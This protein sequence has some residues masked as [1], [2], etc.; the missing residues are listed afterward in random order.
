MPY[1]AVMAKECLDKPAIQTM[2][3]AKGTH[4]SAINC[5]PNGFPCSCTNS[6]TSGSANQQSPTP[7][8]CLLVCCDTSQVFDVER[9]FLPSI[10]TLDLHNFG[11]PI[12]LLDKEL[13]DEDHNHDKIQ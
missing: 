6:T 7:G 4:Q 2:V 13:I 1:A 10:C 12:H 8:L 3:K 11:P 9:S 5:N